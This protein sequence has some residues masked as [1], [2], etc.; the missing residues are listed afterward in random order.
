[1]ALF[2]IL[3]TQIL[4]LEA[5]KTEMALKKNMSW[6]NSIATSRRWVYYDIWRG[7]LRSL[8]SSNLTLAH[9]KKNNNSYLSY[10]MQLQVCKLRWPLAPE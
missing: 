6:S 10:Q 3:K 1:M 8:F 9:N 7:L 2:R 4:N 5:N